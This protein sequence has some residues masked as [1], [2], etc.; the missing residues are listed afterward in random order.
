M[1]VSVAGGMGVSV[2]GGMGVSVGSGWLSA[3][4]AGGKD[5]SPSTP[6]PST[7]SPST[8]SSVTVATTCAASAGEM[9]SAGFEV[10]IALDASFCLSVLLLSAGGVGSFESST[11]IL[12]V[13]QAV[14]NI[15][16]VM[17]RI[18]MVC[19]FLMYLLLIEFLF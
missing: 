3:G 8:P 14:K 15:A 19:L 10:G 9:F 17:R 5:A 13:P 18:K 2:A 7:P 4:A 16:M 12:I 1:G 11:P 6:S